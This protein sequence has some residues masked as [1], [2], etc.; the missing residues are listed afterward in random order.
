MEENEQ[1]SIVIFDNQRKTSDGRKKRLENLR[2][3]KPGQSGNLKGRPKKTEQLAEIIDEIM[4]WKVI[5][6]MIEKLP[7]AYRK[8]FKKLSFV[9]AYSIMSGAISRNKE[10]LKLLGDIAEKKIKISGKFDAEIGLKLYDVDSS[11]YPRKD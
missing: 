8:K 2:P 9:L 4:N 7:K 11:R 6:E 1:K 3:W 10:C 5:P